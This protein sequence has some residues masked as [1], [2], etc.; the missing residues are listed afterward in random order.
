[1]LVSKKVVVELVLT[2]T[3]EEVVWLH[4]V[5]Q[6]KLGDP[7]VEEDVQDYQMRERFFNATKQDCEAALGNVRKS[8]NNLGYRLENVH[9]VPAT[10]LAK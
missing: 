8:Y 2:L 5:M 4:S 3:E 10:I 9:C 6:N 7:D 1:M